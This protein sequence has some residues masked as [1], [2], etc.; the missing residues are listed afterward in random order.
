MPKTA[1]RQDKTSIY[2]NGSF[3]YPAGNA[4]PVSKLPHVRMIAK[5][6]LGHITKAII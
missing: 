4:K 2:K 5:K 1:K 3:E 6:V